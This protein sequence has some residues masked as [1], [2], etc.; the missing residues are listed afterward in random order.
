MSDDFKNLLTTHL[1]TMK[2]YAVMLTRDRALADDLLQETALKAW[3]AQ[4]QFTMGTNFSAWMYRILRNQFISTIRRN[5]NRPACVDDVSEE[6]MARS[7]AQEEHVLSREVIRAMD[8]LPYEQR[9][10]MVLICANGL[11]YEDAAAATGCTVGTIKS[12]LWRAR[13]KMSALL[14]GDESV[15]EERQSPSVEASNEESAAH[16]I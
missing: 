13:T 14:L 3:A 10:V 12:R 1:P 2:A 6:F 15:R 5:K 11:S 16:A 4:S 7:G 8:R 9:E